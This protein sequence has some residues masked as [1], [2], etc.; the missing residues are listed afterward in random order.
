R[1]GKRRLDK[2][3]ARSGTLR[4]RGPEIDAAVDGIAVDLGEFVSREVG[5]LQSRYGI[6]NLFW[7]ASPYQRRGD[8]L[9]PEHPG[10]RHLGQRLAAPIGDGVELANPL[11]V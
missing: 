8:S 5:I 10:Q 11:D 6:S 4:R 2:S 9:A 1:A 7:A 3:A